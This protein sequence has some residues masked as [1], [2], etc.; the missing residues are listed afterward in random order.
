MAN[1]RS[2]PYRT[3]AQRAELGRVA[4]RRMPRSAQANLEL[5]QDRPDPVAT[6][7]AEG[8]TRLAE[9]LPLRY[10]RMSESAFAFY[11]GGAGIMA[12][13]LSRGPNSRVRT[14]LCGDMHLSNLGVY[15]SPERSLLFDVNDF[16]ETLP[17]PFEWD[18]K[19]LATSFVV[20]GQHQGFSARTIERAAARVGE[21]YRQ[22]IKELASRG[23]MPAWYSRIRDEF[24][25]SA[26]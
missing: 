12:F 5:S 22:T 7:E 6:L 9:L 18:V 17:G 11:R 10:Q 25:L 23:V 8:S 1:M 26:V 3:K 13:D 16:D 4:R 21:S 24:I 2:R 14:Q 19:R 20:A 15:G